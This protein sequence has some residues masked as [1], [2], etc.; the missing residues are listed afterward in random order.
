MKKN[1]KKKQTEKKGNK[2]D[3]ISNAVAS[4]PRN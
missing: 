1:L 2:F 3:L 4:H